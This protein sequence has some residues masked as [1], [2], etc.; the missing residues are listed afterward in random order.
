MSNGYVRKNNEAFNWDASQLTRA[1]DDARRGKWDD[2]PEGDYH[3]DAV[4]F[5][6]DEDNGCGYACLAREYFY[7]IVS[8]IIGV[9]KETVNPD[10]DVSD[11]WSVTD[12]G[13]LA[14]ENLL[15]Y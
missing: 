10:Y 7:H 14:R 9:N 6:E 13:M 11:R 15:G 5:P 4:F 8:V 2:Y 3:S 1:M 12:S